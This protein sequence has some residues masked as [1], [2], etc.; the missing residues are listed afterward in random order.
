[1][2]VMNEKPPLGLIPK[3]VREAERLKEVGSAIW[4][5]LDACEVIPMKWIEEYN[6]LVKKA[7]E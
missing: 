3:Y 2:N 7:K 5:Y 6:E 1:M 4:R